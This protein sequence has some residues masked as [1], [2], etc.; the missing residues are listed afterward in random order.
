MTSASPIISAAAVEAVRAGWRIAFS[1]ASEPETPPKRAP[2]QPSVEASGGTSFGATQCHADEADDDTEADREEA[3]DAGRAGR[4]AAEEQQSERNRERDEGRRQPEAG[5]AGRREHALANGRD[6]LDARCAERR[7]QAGEHRHDGADDQ[8]DDHGARRKDGVAVR[9]V[10]AERDEQR[11]E[12]LR[13]PEPDE[14]ARD[15]GEDADHAALDDHRGHHLSPRR[16][17]SPQRSEFA[18]A[19]RNRDRERVGDHEDSDEQRDAAERE[20]ELL[21][22]ARERTRVLHLLRSLLGAASHLSRGRQ[23]RPDLGDELRGRD[24]LPRG[25][26]D[27]VELP[28]LPK[29]FCAV[30][31]SKI[32][33]VAPPIDETLPSFTTPVIRYC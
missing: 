2:G 7:Q 33:M 24:A 3:L 19:L 23:D 29:I 6:R 31:R 10:D 13:D 15:R 11:L 12:A 14:E 18:R 30:G 17:Q 25:D 22:D 32:A 20:Q 16:A 26:V 21:Q 27:R 9:Q 28:T 5:E 1:R 4:E 8:R